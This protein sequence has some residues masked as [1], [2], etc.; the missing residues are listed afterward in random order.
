VIA[1]Y[2]AQLLDWHVGLVAGTAQMALE[3][4]SEGVGPWLTAEPFDQA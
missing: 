4:L 2:V 3:E 1:D